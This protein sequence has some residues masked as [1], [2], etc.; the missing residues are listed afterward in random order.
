MSD[1]G[2]ITGKKWALKAPCP[3]NVMDIFPDEDSVSLPLLFNRGI[4]TAEDKANFFSPDYEKDLHDP[5]LLRDMERVMGF[6]PSPWKL[7]SKKIPRWLSRWIVELLIL[8]K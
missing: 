3:E 1:T 5:F 7:W 4:K 6:P 8:R 2:I